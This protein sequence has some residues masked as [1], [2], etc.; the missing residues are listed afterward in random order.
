MEDLLERTEKRVVNKKVMTALIKAGCFDCWNENRYE[1]MNQY[2][3]IRKVKDVEYYNIEDYC[4]QS[5]IEFEMESLEIALTA[6]YW[7]DDVPNEEKI[8][9]DCK[10][11]KVQEKYDRNNKLMAF[12]NV[13][14]INENYPIELV[15]FS[16]TYTRKVDLF[17]T[18][19]NKYITVSGKKDGKK[20]IV[21]NVRKLN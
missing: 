1:V 2:Y 12:V 6:H 19:D 17:D 16:S 9:F 20:V 14:S 5:I 4:K 15:V 11:V 10:I 8:T 21:N 7:F 18:V 3:D 13:V